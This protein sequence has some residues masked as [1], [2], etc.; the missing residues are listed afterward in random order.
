MIDHV[1]VSVRDLHRSGIFYGAALRSLGWSAI[2]T[3]R[4]ASGP[5]GIPDL[6]GFGDATGASIWL[7]DDTSGFSAAHIGFVAPDRAAVDV[8]YTSARAAG[9][10]DNGA[11]AVRDYFAPG[12]YAANV[13]DPDGNSLE[14]VAKG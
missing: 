6:T 1:F 10:R 9:A 3:Y 13:F 2:G 11:P 5:A 12:Y 7:R 4:A 14:F 8:A